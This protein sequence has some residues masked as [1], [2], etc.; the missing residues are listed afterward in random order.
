VVSK[1]LVLTKLGV[2]LRI[3]IFGP[4]DLWWEQWLAAKA[5]LEEPCPAEPL[6]LLCLQGP[7]SAALPLRTSPP[8]LLV[9]WFFP[10]ASPKCTS[11]CD[12]YDTPHMA[13]LLLAALIQAF[14]PRHQMD[15]LP[16]AVL[17]TL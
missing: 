15:S 17:G 1:L 6:V 11:L 16:R 9:M 10:A 8:G 13:C 14:F 5:R 3:P 4:A 2:G 7:G 12:S